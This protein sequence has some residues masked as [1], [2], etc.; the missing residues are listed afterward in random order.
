MAALDA[1]LV[2]P[3]WAPLVSN[4][5]PGRKRAGTVRGAVA[6]ILGTDQ[7]DASAIVSVAEVDHAVGLTLA[8]KPSPALELELPH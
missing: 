3:L 5:P 7:A 1:T 4:W 8:Q 6:D 2:L